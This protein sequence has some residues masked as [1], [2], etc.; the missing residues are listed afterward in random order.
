MVRLELLEAIDCD[1]PI[2]AKI[3]ELMSKLVWPKIPA[4]ISAFA[5]DL[6]IFLDQ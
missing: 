1:L 2:L 6:E 5:L 4:V 3:R